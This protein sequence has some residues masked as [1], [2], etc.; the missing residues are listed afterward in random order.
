MEDER[1][2]VLWDRASLLSEFFW[3]RTKSKRP[4]IK[5]PRSSKGHCNRETFLTWIWQRYL[6]FLNIYY[7]KLLLH[8]ALHD[9]SIDPADIFFSSYPFRQLFNHFLHLKACRN[10]WGANDA[11]GRRLLNLRNGGWFGKQSLKTKIVVELLE[12]LFKL[13]V[14][15]GTLT[16]YFSLR[17]KE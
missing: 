8:T 17:R 2:K 14:N 4:R 10:V 1:G 5:R 9:E 7:H 15:N 13:I 11:N 12:K 3:R 16:T 6:P